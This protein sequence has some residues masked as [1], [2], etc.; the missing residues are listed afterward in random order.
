MQLKQFQQTWFDTVYD[1]ITATSARQMVH[2]NHYRA[3]LTD[4]LCQSYQSI[5]SL[6]GDEYFT[7]ITRRHIAENPLSDPCVS[8]YGDTFAEFLDDDPNLNYLGDVARIDW[9]VDQLQSTYFGQN[10]YPLLSATAD[11]IESLWFKAGRSVIIASDYAISDIYLVAN[12]QRD[13]ADIDTGQIVHVYGL[14]TVEEINHHEQLALTQLIKG[15]QLKDL[16]LETLDTQWLQSR[17]S[18]KT[19]TEVSHDGF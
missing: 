1:D 4:A 14:G 2:Q 17:L 15:C 12:S 5:L 18:D 6:V 16:A 9:A 3:S 8:G 19:I 7:Q 13:S 10:L 11:T